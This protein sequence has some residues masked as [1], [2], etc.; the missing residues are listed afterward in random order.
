MDHLPLSCACSVDSTTDDLFSWFLTHIGLC[1]L[2][3]RNLASD[4]NLDSPCFARCSSAPNCF[5]VHLLKL[6]QVW[7]GPFT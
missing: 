7:Y 2:L 5:L 3:C 1:P 4:F 6:E